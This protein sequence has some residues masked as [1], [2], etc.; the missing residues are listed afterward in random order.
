[1]LICKNPRDGGDWSCD[2]CLIWCFWCMQSSNP[3]DFQMM[4][5]MSCVHLPFPENLA[6]MYQMQQLFERTDRKWQNI[7][8]FQLTP[9]AP[10]R[11]L[12]VS[13][14][15]CR[16]CTFIFLVCSLSD[17]LPQTCITFAGTGWSLI[18]FLLWRVTEWCLQVEKRSKREGSSLL[19]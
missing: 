15:T 16:F 9:S 3:N 12:Q 7:I 18:H 2:G 8:S 10:S 5:E 17:C 1:M 19:R 14:D 6:C 11:L 4:K 13:L